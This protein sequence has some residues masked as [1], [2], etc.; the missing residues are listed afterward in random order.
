VVLYRAPSDLDCYFAE[1]K[2]IVPIDR[3]TASDK[4][5][6]VEF[7]QEV[8]IRLRTWVCDLLEALKWFHDRDLI[9]LDLKSSNVIIHENGHLM[10]CDFDAVCKQSPQCAA[11]LHNRQHDVVGEE[12]FS[13]I[14]AEGEARWAEDWAPYKCSKRA[15]GFRL[16]SGEA[17][18][19][20]DFFCLR[21]LLD[22]LRRNAISTIL[23][24]YSLDDLL[25]I[26]FFNSD[27]VNKAILENDYS[28]IM[29]KTDAHLI[30]PIVILT[31][32]KIDGLSSDFL[33][34]AE[35]ERVVHTQI[36][37]QIDR[38][39]DIPAPSTST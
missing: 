35:V 22:A 38:I 15:P 31:R 12:M 29:N 25:L 1:V 39:W 37:N 34:T 23:R 9:L 4:A 13:R 17:T 3:E 36:L 7:V 24:K 32:I 2:S 21:N 28:L 5:R 19:L 14:A 20:Q 16:S 26:D 18:A 33:A 11:K 27:I 30:I 6:E 10:V 8:L